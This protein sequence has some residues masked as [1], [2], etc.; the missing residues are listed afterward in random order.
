MVSANEMLVEVRD[1]AAGEV[2]DATST[3]E[4][5]TERVSEL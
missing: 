5:G 2:H 3:G 4:R 1:E